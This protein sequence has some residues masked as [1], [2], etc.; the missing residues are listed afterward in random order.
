[1]VER[2]S[3]KDSILKGMVWITNEQSRDDAYA[4]G[5][6]KDCTRDDEGALADLYLQKHRRCLVECRSHHWDG[7]M[8]SETRSRGV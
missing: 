6:A 1:M 3:V 7:A 8:R 2:T 5:S 4:L